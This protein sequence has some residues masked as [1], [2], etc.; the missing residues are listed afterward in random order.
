M[1]FIR[2]KAEKTLTADARV[3]DCCA[4]HSVYDPAGGARVV[5]G[6]VPQPLAAICWSTTRRP[7]SCG[8]SARSAPSSST[9]FK[10]EPIKLAM[11]Y[12]GGK[13]KAPAGD[14]A[15]VRELTEFCRNTIQ[16]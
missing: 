14:R 3:I 10:Q 7:T 4:D 2:Y 13:A 6:P 16:C 5:S 12:G 9:I 11:E 15:I 8:R 1:S